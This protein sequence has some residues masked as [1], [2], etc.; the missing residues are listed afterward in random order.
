MSGVQVYIA[1][2]TSSQVIRKQQ[3]KISL[4]LDGKKSKFFLFFTSSQYPYHSLNAKVIWITI[5]E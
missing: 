5:P 1:S 2:V 3:E 4:I